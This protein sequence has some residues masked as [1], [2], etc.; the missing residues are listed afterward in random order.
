MLKQTFLYIM[1]E[2]IF[3]KAPVAF[4]QRRDNL[5][6]GPSGIQARSK[7]RYQKEIEELKAKEPCSEDNGYPPHPVPPVPDPEKH[8]DYLCNHRYLDAIVDYNKTRVTS[9]SAQAMEPTNAQLR[10]VTPGARDKNAGA[11]SGSGFYIAP[12]T[13][14]GLAASTGCSTALVNNLPDEVHTLPA[15][16]LKVNI[17]KDALIYAYINGS[18]GTPGSC[19]FLHC[20][21]TEPSGTTNYLHWK[22]FDTTTVDYY[23]PYNHEPVEA[24]TPIYSNSGCTDAVGEIDIVF[25]AYATHNLFDIMAG[26]C[27]STEDDV[28]VGQDSY[29]G[30]FSLNAGWGMTFPVVYTLKEK[31]ESTDTLWFRDRRTGTFTLFPS[32]PF[33]IVAWA[34]PFTI[35]D[36][37]VTISG[38]DIKSST[39]KVKN[40]DSAVLNDFIKADEGPIEILPADSSVRYYLRGLLSEYIYVPYI[41]KIAVKTDAETPEVLGKYEFDDVFDYTNGKAFYRWKK[42]S[43]EGTGPAVVYTCDKYLDMVSADKPSIYSAESYDS[44]IGKAYYAQDTPASADYKFCE[45]IGYNG[46]A[47]LDGKVQSPDQISL[48]G[49]PEYTGTTRENTTFETVDGFDIASYISNKLWNTTQMGFGEVSSQTTLY[50]ETAFRYLAFDEYAA[51]FT[52]AN[53]KSQAYGVIIEADSSSDVGSKRRFLGIS[54]ADYLTEGAVVCYLIPLTD[55]SY[56]STDLSK[57]GFDKLPAY[58]YDSSLNSIYGTAFGLRE[59]S[60]DKVVTTY[61]YI[62]DAT[63]NYKDTDGKQVFHFACVEDKTMDLFTKTLTFSKSDLFFKDGGE[64]QDYHTLLYQSTMPYSHLMQNEQT[65]DNLTAWYA[66]DTKN[67]TNIGKFTFSTEETTEEG[68]V[69]IAWTAERLYGSDSYRTEYITVG[70]DTTV[71]QRYSGLDMMKVVEGQDDV[72][73]FAWASVAD[74]TVSDC[75]FTDTDSPVTGT[76]KAWTYNK[77]QG[78]WSEGSTVTFHPSTLMYAWEAFGEGGAKPWEWFFT[79]TLDVTSSTE[80]WMESWGFWTK[81]TPTVAISPINVTTT[82]HRFITSDVEQVSMSIARNVSIWTDS[83][84]FSG[85]DST[86]FASNYDAK[87]GYPTTPNL[88]A[89][90]SY[91]IVHSCYI[92]PAGELEIEV[93]GETFTCTP[94]YSGA[95]RQFHGVLYSGWFSKE[96]NMTFYTARITP[97]LADNL[98]TLDANGLI[99][100]KDATIKSVKSVVDIIYDRD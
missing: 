7:L 43:T 91:R 20:D 33:T 30:W 53:W 50:T 42:Y 35:G 76:T 6:K 66:F 82:W 73:M 98:Y 93:K 2:N 45:R 14:T 4:I 88:L 57:S 80:L 78:T 10:I 60:G 27:R 11:V 62:S 54:N 81:I 38:S 25:N 23:T 59:V 19:K 34:N 40:S 100:E 36:V 22:S 1:S 83:V 77:E 85:K 28:T 87:L 48:Y 18:S 64:L 39:P 32:T 97:R 3:H 31:P 17:G 47:S 95:N 69:T 37:D 29:L 21:N 5:V 96:L 44:Y 49:I 75:V 13:R 70:T 72:Q 52:P 94:S 56:E 51:Q 46:Y 79:P 58:V 55:E 63:G 92:A 84:D 74:P 12:A 90:L 9:T 8:S 15:T 89:P 41:A 67:I 65:G 24:D 61:H 86:I 99:L 26:F 16:F 68:T 71:Y